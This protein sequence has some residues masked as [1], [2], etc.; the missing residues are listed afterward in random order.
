MLFPNNVTNHVQKECPTVFDAK[1]EEEALYVVKKD[2]DE[3]QEGEAAG[4]D[5]EKSLNTLA[6]MFHGGRVINVTLPRFGPNCKV[7]ELCEK[8]ADSESEL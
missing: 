2:D 5:V 3:D 6:S 7:G 1:R 4:D 8:F